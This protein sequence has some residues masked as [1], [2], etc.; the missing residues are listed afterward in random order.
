MA[1]IVNIYQTSLRIVSQSIEIS[2]LQCGVGESAALHFVPNIA[3]FW[4]WNTTWVAF[5]WI[6]WY[7]HSFY[8]VSQ[9]LS[10][11]LYSFVILT[12]KCYG[13]SATIC[14]RLWIDL[15]EC[16]ILSWYQGFFLTS[17]SAPIMAHLFFIVNVKHYVVRIWH[18]PLNS[19]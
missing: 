19:W 9:H 11:I 17:L 7:F 6:A 15:E 10:N 5:I 12:N 16:I 8:M 18:N 14:A 4:K 13:T 2:S 3:L 1:D